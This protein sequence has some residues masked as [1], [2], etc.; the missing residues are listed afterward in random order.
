MA[1]LLI[2]QPEAALE[3]ALANDVTL[4]GHEIET[5]SGNIEALHRAREH[6]VDVVITSPVTTFSEDLA[7]TKEMHVV[8]PGARLIVLAPAATNEDIV[9]ALRE[10]VFACFTPPF[11][12]GEIAAMAR[13]GLSEP[14]QP[15]GIELVSGLPHWLTVRVSCQLLT[16]ERL[17]RFIAE[18]QSALPSGERDLLLT[19]FREMLLNAMEHG[20][21]FDADKV[22]EVTAAKTARAIVYHF[23]DPGNGFDRA[24]LDHCAGSN[25]PETVLASAEKRIELGLRPGGFGM[26][27]VR[28]IVDELV[29]NERGNEVLLIKHLN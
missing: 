8:R 22:I 17:V 25:S 9:N 14:G 28:Q 16:A 13:G 10:D 12:Y 18:L 23:R 15:D 21:G 27:I 26:L 5:C 2:I 20:A 3:K 1:R 6:A 7:F 11:D 19:A 24:D 4:R 29:Y